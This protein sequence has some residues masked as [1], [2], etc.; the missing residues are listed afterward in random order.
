MQHRLDLAHDERQRDEDRRQ[1]HP[2]QREDHRQRAAEPAV[3]AP[4]E[5]QR[6]ADD[7]RRDRERQ[8]DDGL[9]QPAA[10]EAARA[11]S[12]SAVTSPKITLSGT[13]IATIVRLRRDRGDRRRASSPTRERADA[14]LER[15][16]EDHPQRDEHEHAEVG[17]RGGAQARS[18][19][20][21][22][23]CVTSRSANST[24]NEITS[25]ATDTAAALAG[26]SISICLA[27]YCDATSVSRGMPP[28][29]ST[30]RAE[31]ADGAG[32]GQPGAAEQRR[33]ERGEDDA[34]ERRPAARAERRGR[35]L[36]LA[37]DLH[38]HGL[39][40]AHDERQRHER[41]RDDQRGAG[42]VEVQ[43]DR[44]AR[45]VEAQQHDRWRRS[46]AARTAG[47]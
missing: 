43:A 12:A 10:G 31:L 5:D 4:E 47:R 33:V 9:Q 45:A 2:G 21:S 44:A 40:G 34:A 24:A 7:H 37:V 20:L 3:V 23:A 14:V 36:R 18:S 15:A 22:P 27:M 29:I 30:T 11:P 42:G 32:E 1:H 6:D 13:T 8:V 46:S 41:E 16:V 25:S 35:L 28:P 19:S 26:R 39:H 38:Q 17:Q